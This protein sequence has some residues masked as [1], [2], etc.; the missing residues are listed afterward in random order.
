M[1]RRRAWPAL[2]LRRSPKVV[3]GLGMQGPNVLHHSQGET[4]AKGEMSQYHS[5][6]RRRQLSRHQCPYD[7]NHEPPAG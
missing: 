4:K 1:R 7:R 3:V 5:T 6:T 2:A